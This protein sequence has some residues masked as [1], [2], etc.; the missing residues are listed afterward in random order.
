MWNKKPWDELKI[1]KMQDYLD[2]KTLSA[3]LD[4]LNLEEII[5]NFFLFMM[6][7]VRR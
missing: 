2:R 6:N 5:H 1:I 4:Y 3:R 7:Q